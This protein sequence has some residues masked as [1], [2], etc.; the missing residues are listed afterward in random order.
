MELISAGKDNLFEY[1]HFQLLCSALHA[2]SDSEKSSPT[3][4]SH[5]M[6]L[7]KHSKLSPEYDTLISK[8]AP[9][10]PFLFHPTNVSNV[11]EPILEN[12]NTCYGLIN[13]ESK[14]VLEG[15]R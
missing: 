15:T 10:V 7:Y 11:F 5:G 4:K 12:I 2:A 9:L 3:I 1:T 13:F 8:Y 14:K 6:K